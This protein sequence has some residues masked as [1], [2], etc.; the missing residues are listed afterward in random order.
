[1]E[2]GTVAAA[3]VEVKERVGVPDTTILIEPTVAAAFARDRG[4][5]PSAPNVEDEVFLAKVNTAENLL[6]ILHSENPRHF[7]HCP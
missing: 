7:T 2:V 1:M 5:E 4:A 3:I 6:M